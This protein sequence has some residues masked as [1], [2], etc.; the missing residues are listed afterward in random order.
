MNNT[1]YK[2]VLTPVDRQIV[3]LPKGAEVLSVESQFNPEGFLQEQVVVYAFVDE[4]E[5]E[6]ESFVFQTRGTGHY[7]GNFKRENYAFLGTVK[8][9]NGKLMFHIFYRKE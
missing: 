1:I 8:L 9:S 4:E 6:T 7:A 5:K 2:Y 3:K